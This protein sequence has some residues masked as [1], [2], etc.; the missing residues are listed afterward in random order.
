MSSRSLM[1]FSLAGILC[2]VAILLTGGCPWIDGGQLEPAPGQLVQSEKPRITSPVL[3]AGDLAELVAANTA[4]AFE[5]YGQVGD[6]DG[7][8]FYSPYSV[9]I[10]LAMTYAGARGE[11]E[12]QMADALHFTLPQDRLHPAF[13]VLDQA[14][15]TAVS[16]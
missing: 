6:G 7:N 11:T 10:A 4:F 16:A 3:P 13:N 8:L 14:L 15:A 9:S 5:L 12:Q 1:Q 2:A